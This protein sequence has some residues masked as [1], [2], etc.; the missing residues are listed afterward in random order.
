LL[1]RLW[2][3]NKEAV[4]GGLAGF[5][6]LLLYA[7]YFVGM[8]MAAPARLAL[9]GAAPGTDTDIKLEGWG[10]LIWKL[11]R[12]VLETVTLP[13]LSRQPRVRRAWTALYRDGNAKL[14]ALGS[15]TRSSF[16]VEPEVLDAWVV[17]AA[18]KVEPALKRLELFKRRQIYVAFPVRVGEGGRVIEKP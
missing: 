3:D 11:G 1:A 15:A 12:S 5:A 8:L 14:E 13:S 6:L 16:I 2:R 9:V 17:R 18:P 7:G 10:A 4:I